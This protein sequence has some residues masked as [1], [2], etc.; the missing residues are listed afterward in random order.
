TAPL[1]ASLPPATPTTN[2]ATG[3][4]ILLVDDD[5]AV[6]EGLRRVLC[7]EGWNI[8]A[9][10][11]GEGA[12]EYLQSHQPDLMI[13]DLSMAE[14][15]GWDLLFHEKLQRPNLPV[16]VITALPVATVG[17][18]D[19]FA[20][21]FFQKPLDLDALIVAVRRYIGT[22]GDIASVDG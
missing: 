3:S 8:I 7:S 19:S 22:P 17:G 20:H 9:T 14:I 15:T 2:H 1:A 10:S 4:T 13:T 12:L 5:P 16:F 18:A 21:E 11:S 6:L